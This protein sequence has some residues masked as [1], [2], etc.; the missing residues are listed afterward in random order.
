MRGR[1]GSKYTWPLS[2]KPRFSLMTVN[3]LET[4]GL[5]KMLHIF[6]ISIGTLQ[7]LPL[8]IENWPFLCIIAI[9]LNKI[10]LE[11]KTLSNYFKFFNSSGKWYKAILLQT[12]WHGISFRL[13][14][15]WH[16]SYIY[17]FSSHNFPVAII[18]H[19]E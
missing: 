19:W 2:L 15:F 7:M 6:A 4:A 14:C 12:T 18:L 11:I 10:L 13:R 16:A 5:G 3:L 8:I 17:N 1:T 9:F